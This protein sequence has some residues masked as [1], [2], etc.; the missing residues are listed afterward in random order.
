VSDLSKTISKKGSR[1]QSLLQKTSLH[2][3]KKSR[4]ASPAPKIVSTLF[5]RKFGFDLD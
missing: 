3:R 2:K 1:A 4:A 5:P